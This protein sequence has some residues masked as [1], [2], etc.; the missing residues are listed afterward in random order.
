MQPLIA[1]LYNGK[2]A[3]ELLGAMIQ[4]QPIRNDY[5][6]VR[7]YWQRQKLWPDFEKG[8]RRAMHDGFIADAFRAETVALKAD[9]SVAA[10]Q[11]MGT[12]RRSLAKPRRSRRNPPSSA[13]A[14]EAA[15]SKARIEGV[16]L[17]FRPDPCIWDGRFA[18]NGWL[19]ECRQA[20]QQ[21]HLGQRGADQ[22]CPGRARGSGDQ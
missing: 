12:L 9:V 2:S 20:S 21:A 16:E 14:G 1:P 5:E 3:Y 19:Q 15:T 6:I 4:Q 10:G 18:N 13:I 22:S 17:C 11:R 8:W 7:D